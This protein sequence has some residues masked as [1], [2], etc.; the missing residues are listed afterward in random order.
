MFPEI[1]VGWCVLG[2]SAPT[3]AK[4]G[5]QLQEQLEQLASLQHPLATYAYR[6][7]SL[8]RLTERARHYDRSLFLTRNHT[9]IQPGQQRFELILEGKTNARSN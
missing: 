9:P 2:P 7:Y 6:F 4:E 1:V 5:Q 8:Q 3:L